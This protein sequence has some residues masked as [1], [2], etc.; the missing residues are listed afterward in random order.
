MFCLG[1][2]DGVADALDKNIINGYKA[3][4]PDGVTAGQLQDVV[5]QYLRLNPADRHFL[6]F[7][8]VADAIS[9]AFPCRRQSARPSSEH[10]CTGFLEVPS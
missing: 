3:C 10:R 8:L 2:I 4:V 1:Y 9:K 5:V 7:G 6:A